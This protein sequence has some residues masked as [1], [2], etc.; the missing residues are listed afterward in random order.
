MSM[1]TAASPFKAYSLWL[2]FG[3]EG[4]GCLGGGVGAA[5]EGAKGPGWNPLKSI[6]ACVS[7]SKGIQISKK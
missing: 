5:V 3:V 6:N 2:P 1:E 4:D 7:L